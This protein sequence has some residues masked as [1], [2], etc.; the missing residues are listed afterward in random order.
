[1]R[2][3][4]GTRHH[5]ESPDFEALA[6]RQSRDMIKMRLNNLGF[7]GRFLTYS[8][9]IKKA[10]FFGYKECPWETSMELF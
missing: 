1:M 3:G 10:K 2:I 4:D 9:I 7:G 8:E 6:N 5:L